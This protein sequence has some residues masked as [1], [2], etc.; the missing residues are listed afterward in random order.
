M[1]LLFWFGVALAFVGGGSLMVIGASIQFTS[2]LYVVALVLVGS[3]PG[4]AIATIA[5]YEDKHPEAVP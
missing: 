4:A 5:Q 2:V 3:M 1:N